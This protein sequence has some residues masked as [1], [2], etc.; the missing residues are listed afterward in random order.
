[1]SIKDGVYLNKEQCQAELEVCKQGAYNADYGK[2]SA[3]TQSLSVNIIDAHPPPTL[4][5]DK[6][7]SSS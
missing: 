7:S 1:M 4:T 2:Q 6:R 3:G 5:R